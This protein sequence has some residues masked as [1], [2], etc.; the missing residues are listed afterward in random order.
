MWPSVDAGKKKANAARD[1]QHVPN[2]EEFD[3]QRKFPEINP[4]SYGQHSCVGSTISVAFITGLVKLVADLKDLRPAPGAM[5]KA[6]SINVGFDKIYLNDSWSHFAFNTSSKYY[7]DCLMPMM[8][9][10]IANSLIA[11]KVQFDGHGKGN[12]HGDNKPKDEMSMQQYYFRLQKLK[13]KAEEK[14]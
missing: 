8:C 5:G 14:E 12:F 6:K 13:R 3:P 1:P 4:Y 10:V 2:P 9:V 11:W 7:Y